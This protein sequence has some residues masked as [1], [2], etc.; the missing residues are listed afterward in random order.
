MKRSTCVR[1]LGS[2]LIWSL[3]GR[4]AHWCVDA[5]DAVLNLV[6]APA[7][8]DGARRIARVMPLTQGPRMYAQEVVHAAAQ[9]VALVSSIDR[10]AAAGPTR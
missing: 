9:P 8:G 1:E 3:A 4:L 10:A 2:I 6:D 5:M 7:D